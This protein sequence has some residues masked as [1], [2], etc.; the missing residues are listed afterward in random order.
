MASWGTDILASTWYRDSESKH[1][2]RATFR[3]SKCGI[4]GANRTARSM[5]SETPTRNDAASKRLRNLWFQGIQENA[6]RSSKQK[7]CSTERVVLMDE[8]PCNISTCILREILT[9]N[10]A[11]QQRKTGNGGL[12]WAHAHLVQWCKCTAV[13]AKLKRWEY[14]KNKNIIMASL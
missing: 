1:Y 5:E 9:C 11:Q 10:S 13:Q 4:S 2:C 7:Q 8:T 6:S 3:A 12:R 14:N